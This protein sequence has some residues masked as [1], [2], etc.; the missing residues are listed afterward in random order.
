MVGHAPQR[1][2]DIAGRI[3]ASH[4][5]HPLAR[6]GFRRPESGRMDALPRKPGRILR[7]R[8]RAVM[9]GTHDQMVCRVAERTGLV[10]AFDHPAPVRA[11]PRPRHA[12]PD[13]DVFGQGETLGIGAH[14]GKHL[15]VRG[16]IGISL[17]HR[18]ITELR[19]M[20]GR[21]RM[22][23][24]V[25]AGARGVGA[26]GPQTAKFPLRFMAD[27][28]GDSG[29]NQVLDRRQAAR[30]RTNHTDFAMSHRS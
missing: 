20:F 6:I 25:D 3:P 15:A 19:Q 4:H 24:V 14:I 1:R 16:K 10:F 29:L 8:R 17:R 9:P 28:V 7:Q 5:Q 11:A 23:G 30:P 2:G 18:K 13:M 27:Y 26:I 22:R 12:R 21:D